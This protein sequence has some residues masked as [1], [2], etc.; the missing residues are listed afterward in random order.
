MVL[1]DNKEIMNGVNIRLC[2]V[3]STEDNLKSGRIKVRLY[4]EDN[5]KHVDDIPYAYPAL[6]KMMSILPKKGECVIIFLTV[7]G[8]GNSNRYYIG[9]VVSQLQNLFFDGFSTGALSNYPDSIIKPKPSHEL[10]PDAKGA[11]GEDEDITFYGRKGTDIILKEN[12]IR[13]RCGSRID[14]SDSEIGKTFNKLNPAYLKLKYNE[15][16]TSVIGDKTGIEYTY[17][18]T[19]TLVADQINLIGNNAKQYFDTTNNEDM[20]SEEEMKKIISQAHVLPYG[21]VLVEFLKYF[22]KMFKE[23]AHPYPGMPTILPSG[24]ETFF[25][26]NFDK[27][28][29]QNVRIN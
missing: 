28:L 1:L 19:A 18:S 2:E 17:N 25:N 11:F 29:S 12:D 21:D 15:T 23:H 6:P 13:I 3:I 16:P 9:P 4:P 24:N 26:Y 5:H 14:S 10:I 22:L 20:I 27:I 7:S 8:K